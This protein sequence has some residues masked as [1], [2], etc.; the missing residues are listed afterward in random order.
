MLNRKNTVC[1]RLTKCLPCKFLILGSVQQ[2]THKIIILQYELLVYIYATVGNF[3]TVN[4]EKA[5]DPTQIC[6]NEKN[7][8][9]NQLTF[10]FKLIKFICFKHNT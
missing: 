5:Y 6:L 7:K 4:A 10:F 9:N 2:K 1:L 8:L 3:T